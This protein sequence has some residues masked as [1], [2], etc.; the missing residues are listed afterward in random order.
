MTVKYSCALLVGGCMLVATPFEAHA[1]QPL[2]A[3]ATALTT[4]F[5]GTTAT[6]AR[7]QKEAAPRPA[8]D[9]TADTPGVDTIPAVAQNTT[10]QEIKQQLATLNSERA[11]LLQMHTSNHPDLIKVTKQIDS[12]NARLRAETNKVLDSL[13]GDSR[14]VLV[15]GVPFKK[16][17]EPIGRRGFNIV[18]LVGDMQH[19][20]GQETV[21]VA[22]RK[23]LADMKDFLPYKVYRLVDTQW[24]L[25]SNSGP[26]IVRLRGWEDQEY[27]LELRAS[28]AFQGGGTVALSPNGIS[29]RFFLRETG[30][31]PA[32]DS[33]RTPLH[34]TEMAKADSTKLEIGREIFQLE[35][36]REDL[37]SR[38]G[39]ARKQAEAGVKDATDARA[40]LGSQL[41]AVIKRISELQQALAE[42]RYKASGRPVIDT[43]FRMEDGE[44]VVVGTS[45]VKGGGKALIALLT[46]TTGRAKGSTK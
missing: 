32:G 7:L 25:A 10:I 15:D 40:A 35:R 28:P 5:D 43:S 33:G 17:S 19:G 11:R 20:G 8:G 18:L 23:A 26:A 30:D 1:Q 45:K 3:S 22:A 41:N 4:P 21:P 14:T 36:E 24:V 6:M 42:T 44:T 29:V 34:P 12:A 16:T 46:A 38:M 9:V 39:L 37:S 13:R 31:G 2:E 27:E